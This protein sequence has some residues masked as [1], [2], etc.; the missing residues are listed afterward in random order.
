MRFST[1]S[2]FPGS[3]VASTI[4]TP[5]ISS[6]TTIASTHV[7]LIPGKYVTGTFGQAELSV[8]IDPASLER[9]LAVMK[10]AAELDGQVVT[11]TSATL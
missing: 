6:S 8:S 2:K 9:K 4:R 3:W 10:M 7:V 11:S 5:T 1:A